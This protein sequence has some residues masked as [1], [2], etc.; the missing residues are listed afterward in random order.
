[1]PAKTTDG[2]CLCGAI[3]FTIETPPKWVAHCHCSMC[4]RAH[5]APF[6]TWVGVET[7][8]FRLVGGAD[9]LRTYAS[10]ADATREFC[11]TCGASLFWRDV[12]HPEVVDVTLGTLDAEPE[13][14]P[15]A[16]I[17]FAHKASW[18]RIPD[19]LPRHDEALPGAGT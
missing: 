4:R 11:G 7:A 14:L 17:W 5:G 1:M 19:D 10:S 2:S 3:R 6:V 8:A 12:R 16:H 18:V 15:V 13:Q 9:V